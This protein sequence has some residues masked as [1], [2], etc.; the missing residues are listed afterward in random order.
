MVISHG[1]STHVILEIF[2][3]FTWPGALAGQYWGASPLVLCWC[4]QLALGCAMISE[5]EELEFWGCV[6]IWAGQCGAETD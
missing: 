4:E 2:L 5:V 6:G 1:S 3:L